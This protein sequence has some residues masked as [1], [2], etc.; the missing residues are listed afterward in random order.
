M[1]SPG[2]SDLATAAP[3]PTDD[4]APADGELRRSE[5][6][7]PGAAPTFADL[8]PSTRAFDL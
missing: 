1:V 7:G 5:P 6:S 4:R 8:P 2:L 3:A